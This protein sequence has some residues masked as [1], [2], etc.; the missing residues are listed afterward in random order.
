MLKFLFGVLGKRS[1]NE[2]IEDSENE[3]QRPT[4]QA[5]VSDKLEIECFEIPDES[6]SVFNSILETL[7][8]EVMV[9]IIYFCELSSLINL[10]LTNKRNY[11]LITKGEIIGKNLNTAIKYYFP[12]FGKTLTWNEMSPEFKKKSKMQWNEVQELNKI[13]KSNPTDF[14]P[15]YP[16]KNIKEFNQIEN[17]LNIKNVYIIKELIEDRRQ[18]IITSGELLLSNYSLTRFP[19][20]CLLQD[21]KFSQLLFNLKKLDLSFNK[22]SGPIPSELAQLTNLEYLILREN[23]FSGCIPSELNEI[24][25]LKVLDLTNNKLSGLIPLE[26]GKLIHLENLGLSK[27]ELHGSIPKELKHMLNLKSLVISHNKL[28]GLIPP[29]LAKLKNLFCLN[30]KNNHLNGPLPQQ[31]G[32]LTNLGTLMLGNNKLS[33]IIPNQLVKLKK[34]QILELNNNCLSGSIPNEL[35]ELSRLL[36]LNL[37][38][39]DLTGSIPNEL[40]DLVNLSSLF[41]HQNKLSGSIPVEL[42]RLI[43]LKELA[44]FKNQLS[45][46]VPFETAQRFPHLVNPEGHIANQVSE[47]SNRNRP[48]T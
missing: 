25:K 10:S 45:G 33:G 12:F 20:S 5:R 32:Q 14:N 48:R 43:K 47:T 42:G 8:N 39:N 19:L 7:P 29:S 37:D 40:G 18:R 41:L 26:L 21:E 17:F 15:I 13:W 31:L 3:L 35:G 24:I 28:T 27:N 2:S 9:K 6:K 30:L 11:S 46:P 1:H 4:K 34:L 36:R 23:N 16:A 22:L 44:L 38:N